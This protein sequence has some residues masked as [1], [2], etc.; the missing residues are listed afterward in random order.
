MQQQI[1]AVISRDGPEAGREYAHRTLAVYRNATR[2]RHP[3]TGR[4][5]YCHNPHF[6]A[7]F[8]RSILFLRQYIRNA[9]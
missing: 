4:R 2:Y 6:R 8:V 3:V 9:H 1:D 5:H 7:A